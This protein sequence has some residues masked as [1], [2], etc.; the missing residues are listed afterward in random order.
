[1]IDYIV[2]GLLV[3][4]IILVIITMNNNINEKA[5][6]DKFN[7]LDKAMLNNLGEFKEQIT[8]N[9]MN[10]FSNLKE[11]F[12][13]FERSL[14][15]EQNEL[16]I[17]MNK[18]LSEELV[19]ITDRLNDFKEDLKKNMNEDFEGLNLKIE[20][21]LM[22]ISEKVN[23]RLDKNFETS[24]KTFTNILQRLTRIDAAQKKIEDLSND[25]V[26]LQAVLTDKSARGAFGEVQMYQ[27]LA[28]IFGEGNDKIYQTQYTLSNNSRADAVLFTPNL[29]TLC[30]DSKFPLS[31]YKVMID[32][33]KEASERD[34]AFKM[35]RDDVKKHINDI[36]SKYIIDEE[37]A[38]QAIMFIPAEAVF[39]ELHAYHFELIEYAQKKRVWMASPTTLMS[40][41]TTLQVILMN[42]EKD[43]YASVIH[44]ELNKLSSEFNRFSER[45]EK[46]SRSIKSVGNDANNLDITTGKIV[47]E[48][49]KINNVEV[50]LIDE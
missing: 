38:D 32:K 45:W 49:A 26:S 42:I 28:N 15:K 41:L 5:L 33:T 4:L 8:R 10:D 24:N 7:E 34:K 36:S 47:K 43:K 17:G 31:N 27:I 9:N 39:A 2:I 40:T 18:S 14:S 13:K 46:L 44:S 3:V 48:F 21:R 29:G 1:M 22:L 30:I 12:S 16:K 23:Q 6:M 35:F 25:I 37:T 50:E 19:R 11:S 20:E